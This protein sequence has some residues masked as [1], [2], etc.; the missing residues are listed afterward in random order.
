MW[1]NSYEKFH[2]EVGDQKFI[3]R[4]SEGLGRYAWGAAGFAGAAGSW[5]MLLIVSF[6]LGEGPRFSTDSARW[7]AKKT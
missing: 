6:L 5:D 3:S 4:S 2:I 7:P 1:R